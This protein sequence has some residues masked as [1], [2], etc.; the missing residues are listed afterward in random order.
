MNSIYILDHNYN[1]FSV[2][3]IPIHLMLF[4]SIFHIRDELQLMTAGPFKRS[5]SLHSN[6]TVQFSVSISNFFIDP[7]TIAG[8]LQFFISPSDVFLHTSLLGFGIH[9]PPSMHVVVKLLFGKAPYL[10]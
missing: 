1:G 3:V 6:I 5:P 7:L 9:S 10:Q 4:G 2:T 8:K